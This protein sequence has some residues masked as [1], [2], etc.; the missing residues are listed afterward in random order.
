MFEYL[1]NLFVRVS[2]DKHDPVAKEFLSE[3]ITYLESVYDKPSDRVILSRIYDL[4][5]TTAKER[6][7]FVPDSDERLH[8]IDNIM[9]SLLYVER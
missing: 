7:M 6:E 3:L 2:A 5:K 8:I 9:E 4:R 1:K